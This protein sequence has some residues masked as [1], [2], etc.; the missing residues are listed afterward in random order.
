MSEANDV[1][2]LVMRLYEEAQ[3]NVDSLYWQAAAMLQRMKED[4]AYWV[5]ATGGEEFKTWDEAVARDWLDD[6]YDV[7]KRYGA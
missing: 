4:R 7:E 6:G 3:D 2:V 1:D 5:C